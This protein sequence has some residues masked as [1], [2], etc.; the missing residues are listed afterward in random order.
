M[1]RV[2]CLGILVVDAL[3]S[4][5]TAYPV[6]GK[7]DQVLTRNLR[8]MPGGGAANSGKAL[9]QLGVDVAVFSKVGDDTNGAFVIDH[10]RQYGVD[11][12]GIRVSPDDTTP[13]TY[14]GI[15]EDG[16]RTFI[17]TPGANKTFALDDL[18]RE[19][20]LDCDVLLYQ[21]LWV[22]PGIDGQPAADLLTEARRRN[23]VTLLDECWGLGPNR[24]VW[25][26]M[27]PCADYVLPSFDDMKAIYPDKDED[28]IADHLLALGCR[29]VV[30]KMGARGC[31][32]CQK[33]ARTRLPSLATLV[34]DTTGAG[35]CFDA[36]FI[37]GLV[38]GMSPEQ[39]ASVGLETAAA[40]I[41]NT[42]G[43]VGIPRFE[44]LR[45]PQRTRREVSGAMSQE[46]MGH[47]SRP[48]SGLM[49]HDAMTQAT[50][51]L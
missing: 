25:E 29:N 51:K 48:P 50:L 44:E 30:L 21:D 10:L 4:P 19:R 23:V 13:F 18:D 16:N 34:V 35:D 43:A 49:T 7:Q 45:S 32:V 40:C 9:A 41:R 33:N 28:A 8:F 42:G 24:E 17:H 12:N 37:A 5:L 20:L 31:M 11:V 3:S 39:A 15:H 27:A 14:V 36:G 6:P 22:L 46:V 47:G 2:H 38:N 26:L 1:K